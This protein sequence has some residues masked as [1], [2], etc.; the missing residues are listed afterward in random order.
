MTAATAKDSSKWLSAVSAEKAQ[1]WSNDPLPIE[2][3]TPDFEAIPR[4]KTGGRAAAVLALYQS[5]LTNRPADQC[6]EWVA[7]EI[8]LDTKL[9]NFASTLAV[10]VDNRRSKLDARLNRF[11]QRRTMEETSPVARNILRTAIVELDLYPKTRAAVV[12]SEAVKLCQMFDTYETGRFVNGV[13]GA[14]VRDESSR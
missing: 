14:I 2:S 4:G 9:R 13:L 12:I 3:L 10:A 6:L 7:S 1:H 5:D 11:S 8:G